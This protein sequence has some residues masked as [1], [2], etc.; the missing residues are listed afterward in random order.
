MMVQIAKWTKGAKIAR[1]KE[2]GQA[3]KRRR[4]SKVWDRCR[5]VMLAYNVPVNQYDCSLR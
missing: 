5:T 4:V 2:E 3:R 1:N